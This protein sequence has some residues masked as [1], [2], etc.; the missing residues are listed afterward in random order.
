M[1]VAAATAPRL[2]FGEMPPVVRRAS[3]FLAPLSA[4]TIAGILT[5]TL[6]NLPGVTIGSIEGS[7]T[8]HLGAKNLSVGS[9][10]LSTTFSGSI[11]GI[12]GSFTKIGTGTLTLT[13]ANT[14]TGVTTV[15]GG[16]LVV[17]N[18]TGSGTGTGPVQVNAGILTGR[19][20]ITGAVT[21]GTG[22][23]PNAALIP[24]KVDKNSGALTIQRAL[25][26]ESNAI[27]KFDLKTKTA[28]ANKVVANAVLI[29]DANLSWSIGGLL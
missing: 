9:N 15:E 4:T 1:L 11:D 20:F 21:I 22:T 27:Y 2:T 6:H 10:N 13:G 18:N 12:A 29:S 14:Y 25:T 8:V 26:L 28:R 16:E 19:G 3:K 24:G 17:D 23:G 5:L 7:G